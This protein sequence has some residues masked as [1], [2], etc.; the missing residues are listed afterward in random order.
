VSL[1][2]I[3]KN[4]P[5]EFTRFNE[6]L[7]YPTTNKEIPLKDDIRSNLSRGLKKAEL[8]RFSAKSK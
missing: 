5:E 3:S 2:R 8:D 7:V 1:K 4:K 6:E